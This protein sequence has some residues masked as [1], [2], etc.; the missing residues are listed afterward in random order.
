MLPV[1]K[2]YP[3]TWAQQAQQAQRGQKGRRE[4]K[5]KRGQRDQWARKESRDQ[6]AILAHKARLVRKAS[7]ARKAFKACKGIQAQLARTAHKGRKAFKARRAT[8]AQ[9]DQ[10]VRQVQ[11]PTSGIW[12]AGHS[13]IQLRKAQSL[14]A[15]CLVAN[16]I[17]F[18][19][20]TS[21]QAT[22]AN[23][24]LLL[25][26]IGLETDTKRYKIG[27]GSTAWNDLSYAELSTTFD[28]A[29]FEGVSAEPSMPDAGELFV[30]SR[31]VG[32][33][34]MLKAKEPSGIDTILQPALF[35]NG[36]YIVAPG[37]TTAMNV[38]GGPAVTAVGTLSHPTLTAASIRTQ[39]SRAQV[40][41]A[42]SANSA[43]EVRAAFARVWRGDAAGLGGFFARF[44]FSI[45][46]TV[47]NQRAF[48][49]LASTTSAISTT[50]D[51]AALTS[52]VGVGN[53]SA[54][55]NLQI[56]HNDGSGNATKVN[57]GSSFPSQGVDD[58]YDLT[59]FCA[60]NGSTISYRM[61]RFGT[62]AIAE[63]TISTDL[64][65]STTFL[66]PHVYMNNGGTAA[67]VQFDLSRIYLETDL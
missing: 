45:V 20:G 31:A 5:E 2:L 41:S 52:I 61:E 37:T 22:S 53:A 48:V 33:R 59:L 14:M 38:Q 28:V 35:G 7:K 8:Q 19:H 16:R 42:A 47:A 15:G 10:R 26:E 1:G 49:G 29:T 66:A 62:P 44:R 6:Q 25:G 60:P 27:D 39:M 9:Q 13:E 55:S 18:R 21:A 23:E 36:T 24:I 64:P 63:G 34:M 4:S 67:L 30:Y 65:P 57:L 17:Q 56:L 46:S 51:P 11:Q 43:A 3:I 40:V 12:T 32:G 54:D 58:V 50:Q